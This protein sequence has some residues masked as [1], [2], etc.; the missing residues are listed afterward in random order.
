MCLN[1]HLKLFRR[2]SSI[3]YFEIEEI[4]DSETERCKTI[5]SHSS[6][7]DTAIIII[8]SDIFYSVSKFTS[9]WKRIQRNNKKDREKRLCL[10]FKAIKKN[11]ITKTQHAK[12]QTFSITTKTFRACI[13]FYFISY[14][15]ALNVYILTQ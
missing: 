11:H 13:I 10:F 3:N 7:L 1:F 9:L 14:L 15:Y 6:V 12:S 8:G 5:M 2:S 4:Y